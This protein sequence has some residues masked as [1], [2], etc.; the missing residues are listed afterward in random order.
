MT[1]D[2]KLCLGRRIVVFLHSGLGDALMVVPMLQAMK[3]LAPHLEIYCTAHTLAQEVLALTN[4]DVRI[5]PWPASGRID[6]IAKSFL[7]LRQLHAD[8]LIVPPGMNLR[9]ASWAARFSGARVSIAAIADHDDKCQELRWFERGAFSEIINRQPGV[10]K[11]DVC[12]SLLNRFGLPSVRWTPPVIPDLAHEAHLLNRL[13]STTEVNFQPGR[14]IGIHLG[15]SPNLSAKLFS[16]IRLLAIIDRHCRQTDSYGLVFWGASEA[17]ST[18]MHLSSL[19]SNSR[20]RIVPWSASLRETSGL[21]GHCAFLVTS[22]SGVMHLA[23]ARG[24]EVCAIFGPT[25][26]YYCGPYGQS[27]NV[28]WGRPSCS[29]CYARPEFFLCP[30]AHTCLSSIPD[31]DI[32]SKAGA[33]WNRQLSARRLTS[34]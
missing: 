10:H 27:Q 7:T 34:I 2:H 28:L 32:L 5:I 15:C 14:I 29:P 4:T 8:C 31:E 13:R 18:R 25:N 24:T 3:R 19:P 11:T 22:D 21:L 33:L 6:H 1:T 23:A 9:K 16:P 12:L 17:E 26:A 30:H 20:I